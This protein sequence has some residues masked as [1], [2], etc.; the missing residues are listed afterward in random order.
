MEFSVWLSFIGISLVILITP[1]VTVAY[2][3]SQTLAH[4]KKA[5]LPLSAG[6]VLG[7]SACFIASVAGLGALLI[8][9][10]SLASVVKFVGAGYLVYIGI[11][12]WL[13]KSKKGVIPSAQGQYNAV[14]LFRGTSII[15]FFNPKGIL[16][17]GAFLPQ[18]IND[19]KSF[20]L[21][22]SILGLTFVTLAMLTSFSYCC[23]FSSIQS[24]PIAQ[25]FK[26]YFHYFSG[27]VL[28]LLGVFSL[29]S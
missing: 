22:S 11:T 28:I 13:A 8:A 4:G 5:T 27:A 23:V 16:F 3:I 6:V 14:A 1:G 12:S 17:F 10:P 26:S 2:L 20:M 21:Q 24:L 7:D 18:F 29:L 15:T 9:F 25:S 19:D